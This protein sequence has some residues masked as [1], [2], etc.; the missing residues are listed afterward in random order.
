MTPLQ[1]PTVS[2]IIPALNEAGHIARALHSIGPIGGDVECL[3]VDGGSSDKTCDVVRH[4][5]G[6]KLL[7]TASPGRARQMNIGASAARGDILIFLHGDCG[8]PAGAITGVRETCAGNE[9]VGGSFCLAFNRRHWVL[10]LC[11]LASRINHPLTTYGD[12][13]QFMRRDAYLAIGGFQEWPLMEDL[14][15]QYRLKQR[16]RLIKIRQPVVS[17]DRRYRKRGP[18]MHQAFNIWLV[19]MYLI[20]VSP[21]R[22][23]KWYRPAVQTG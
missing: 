23:A 8:L 12:Q 1:N 20:G 11:S 5:P 16:G 18:L 22:L 7:T 9:I 4:W 19:I 15:I 14:E 6:V 2:I 21:I 17:S 10:D 13:A 3:V